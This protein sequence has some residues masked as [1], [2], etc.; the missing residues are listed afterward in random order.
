MIDEK[1]V[2]FV[3]KE[4]ATI[5]AEYNVD[6]AGFLN[7]IGY[8]LMNREQLDDALV[9][10]KFNLDQ[11]PQ[12]A[13]CYDSLA[14]CFMTRNENEQAIKYYKLAYEKIPSDTTAN[15][16]FKQFLKE[17]IEQRLQ[18]LEARVRS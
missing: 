1:G 4:F 2:D 9:I 18:E 16:Q 8:N 11:Y 12:V 13:N 5:K 14:E 15:A 3:V 7:I 10:F 17:G 6:D